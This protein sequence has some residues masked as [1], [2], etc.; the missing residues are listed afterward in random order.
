[1]A[2]EAHPNGFCVSRDHQESEDAEH[3][4]SV[5]VDVCQLRTSSADPALVTV[6]VR[7]LLSSRSLH[8]VD[9]YISCS[10]E[11]D[12]FLAAHVDSI[13]ICDTETDKEAAAGIRLLFWQVRDPLVWMLPWAP[14]VL[15]AIA[16]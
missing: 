2:E 1:M 13:R 14:C 10:P 15:R 12:Q 5:H 11:E 4:V 9:Q 3:R 7:Q 8:Y 6:H 16:S